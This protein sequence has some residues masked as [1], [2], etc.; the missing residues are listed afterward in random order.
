MQDVLQTHLA[1]VVR[2]IDAVLGH[3]YGKKN[4]QLIMAMLPMAV[5]ER[6]KQEKQRDA[7]ARNGSA[8]R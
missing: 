1:T 5:T 6:A 8:V 7:L 2:A 3:D 4:P